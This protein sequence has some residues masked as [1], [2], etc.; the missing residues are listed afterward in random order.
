MQTG[1]C[2][3]A[4]LDSRQAV[5]LVRDCRTCDSISTFS[6]TL[7]P[8]SATEEQPG[9][10][11]VLAAQDCAITGAGTEIKL[12]PI[13]SSQGQIDTLRFSL[14]SQ[15]WGRVTLAVQPKDCSS[16]CFAFTSLLAHS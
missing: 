12:G 13:A 14:D 10:G 15:V 4:G 7:S 16:V 5:A 1:V 2:K 11:L 8:T 3:A 6:T 9:S